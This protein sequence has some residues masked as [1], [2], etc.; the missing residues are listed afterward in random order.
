M[1]KELKDQELE[2]IVGG[3]VIVSG[4]K[5]RVGF[6]TLNEKYN[7]K[8]CTFDQV[9]G[10]IYSMYGQYTDTTGV[11]FDTAVRSALFDRGWI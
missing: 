10:V 1:K 8:N 6:T 7:L 9:M 3:T 2:N 11:S 5:M 4:D